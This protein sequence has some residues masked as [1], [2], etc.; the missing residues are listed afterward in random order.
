MQRRSKNNRPWC[1]CETK[2]AAYSATVYG[3]LAETGVLVT[4]TQYQSLLERKI[5]SIKVPDDIPGKQ[6]VELVRT[7]LGNV[8]ASRTIPA[9]S[10]CFR[11]AKK[12]K[13]DSLHALKTNIEARL[14][15]A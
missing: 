6:L 9:E 13:F 14:E 11:L 5:R 7:H 4:P 10:F 8:I 12:C 3:R 1:V 2:V 15:A